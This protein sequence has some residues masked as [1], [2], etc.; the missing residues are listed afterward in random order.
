MSFWNDIKLGYALF[1]CPKSNGNFVDAEFYRYNWND[2]S[3]PASPDI[4][5]FVE[6]SF[7]LDKNGWRIKN[8]NV[9][10]KKLSPDC[11]EKPRIEKWTPTP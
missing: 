1:Y 6:F 9:S 10:L 11:E 5:R 4:K 3:T 2:L 7:G 8:G